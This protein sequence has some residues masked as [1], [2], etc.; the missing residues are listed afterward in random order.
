MVLRRRGVAPAYVPP[1]S[2]VL[3][4]ARD[5]YIAGLT[6]F[7]GDGVLEWVEQFASAT[8]RSANLAQR[9][10][11]QVQGL[12]TQWR[13]QLAAAANPRADAAAW[14]II[15]ILPAHPVITGPVAA[16]AAGRSKGPIYEG[17]AQLEAAGILL[18]LSTSRRNQ[19]WEGR[20]LLDL[21]ERLEAG[22]SVDYDV[23]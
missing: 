6:Q 10:L 13:G 2:I 21:L 20:G 15:N 16:A 4:A 19:S 3:A 17:L 22:G 7:R 14:A 12:M 9:Y 8:A 18:P 11:G 23:G 1:I 5:R